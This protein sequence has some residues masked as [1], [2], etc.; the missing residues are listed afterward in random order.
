MSNQENDPAIVAET[1]ED[2]L[3]ASALPQDPYNE[4]VVKTKEKIGFLVNSVFFQEA[5]QTIDSYAL[6]FYTDIMK[7]TAGVAGTIGMIVTVW[8]A[9]ND[10]LIGHW[11][12]N[13]KFKSGESVRP[14]LL[15]N[16]VPFAIFFILCWIAPNVPMW[17]KIAYAILTRCFLSVF[18]TIL[19][20]P[21]NTMPFLASRNKS[22]RLSMG[23]MNSTGTLI[24]LS[25]SVIGCYPLVALFGGGTDANGTAI[26]EA[27][28]FFLASILFGLL[29]A[30]GFIFYYF[31][32]KERVLDN[33][34]EEKISLKES[35]LLLIRDKNWVQI[36]LLNFFIAITDT[37]CLAVMTYYCKYIIG[38]TMYAAF[39]FG[40]LL[41][42]GA[43]GTAF[44]CKPLLRRFGTKGLA[45]ATGLVVVFGHSLMLIAPASKVL[46]LVAG[47]MQGIKVGLSQALIPMLYGYVGDIAAYTKGGKRLDGMVTTVSNFFKKAGYALVSF[48]IGIS[49]EFS[50]YD[51]NLTVQPA[52]AISMLKIMMIWVPI[53]TGVI[54]VLYAITLKI[55]EN[56]KKYGLA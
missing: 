28:G 22:D 50:K 3:D 35:S 47:I 9:I 51:G 7:I 23:Q 37:S 36:T 2:A 12:V 33:K 18:S 19:N 43:L 20:I 48:L 39:A 38:N 16:S 30:A 5:M 44:L 32:S 21:K 53:V 56:A 45:L 52:S 42:G 6:Y 40:S 29:A 46:I 10:P 17:A 13:H 41:I 49:L 24:G 11:T 54:V 8:D 14:H 34:P 27:R 26:H 15:Y 4:P 1:P 25:L 55:E 31:T